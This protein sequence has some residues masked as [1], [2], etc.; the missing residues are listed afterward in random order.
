MKPLLS[1]RNLSI[2]FNTSKGLCPAVENLDLEVHEGEILSIVGE[3]GS[4]KSVSMLALLRL[5]GTNTKITMDS[6]EFGGKNWMN[7][8]NQDMMRFIGENVGMI[9]Q[10]PFTSL[11][12]SFTVGW[13]IAEKLKLYKKLRGKELKK[14][15]I[16]LLEQ[17]G[18]TDPELR[19]SSFPHQLSGGMNQRAMIAMAIS[20]KPKLLIADE[21]TTA[22]DVTIQGQI[23]DLLLDL[24]KEYSLGLILITHDMGVVHEMADRVVV[25]YAG[26]KVEE[27]TKR[28]IFD[29]PTHPYTKGLLDSLPERNSAKRLLSIK[30]NMPNI[31]LRPSGCIFHPRCNYQD[32]ICVSTMPQEIPVRNG[33]CSC[34]HPLNID[35]DNSSPSELK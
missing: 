22:L 20:C 31:Y 18:I 30:G 28:H 7:I 21:P 11:N 17:V 29:T 35:Q 9:F 8:S 23:L 15:V 13:Q 24:Q 1:V 27:N 34:H 6:C 5:L 3:S 33:V 19:Y 14:A 2:Y 25:L 4:G 16:D 10:E 32:T 26:R 12:P